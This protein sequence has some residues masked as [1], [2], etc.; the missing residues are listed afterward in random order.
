V[1]I[2]HS[3][4]WEPILAKSGSSGTIF[5]TDIAI[6]PDG[7]Y[8]EVKGDHLD[9]PLTALCNID[10]GDEVSV[11]GDDNQIHDLAARANDLGP[12]CNQLSIDSLLLVVGG[13]VVNDDIEALV[14][15]SF[16]H[17]VILGRA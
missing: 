5:S 9:V 13:A 16:P 15:R 4:P 3:N 12:L 7:L 11:A 10:Q 17:S 2:G 14:L 6:S 1:G 8:T